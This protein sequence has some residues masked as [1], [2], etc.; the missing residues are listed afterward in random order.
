GRSPAPTDA[1]VSVAPGQP[2]R[3]EVTPM[4]SIDR[5]RE[6]VHQHGVLWERALFIHL[7]EGGSRE[8]TLRALALHQNEDGGWGHALEHDVRAPASHAVATEYALGLMREFGLA[9]PETVMRTAEWCA[10][11]QRD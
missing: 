11:A 1:S 8:R 2:E 7:F 3:Q 4:V 9:E 5:A 10:R 6:F